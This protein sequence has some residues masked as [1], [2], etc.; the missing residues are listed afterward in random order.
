MNLRLSRLC[1]GSHDE[2]QSR[3]KKCKVWV[4]ETLPF[5]GGGQRV[6]LEVAR[7]LR[8]TGQYHC[9]FLLPDGGPLLEAVKADGFPYDTF[10][11]G[12]Y[13]LGVKNA[14]DYIRFT[15]D[16]L[17]A[18][19]LFARLIRRRRPCLVY[20]GGTRA[21]IWSAIFGQLFSI[22]ILWHIHHVMTDRTTV[23][24]LQWVGQLPAVRGI[25]CVS[26]CVRTQYPRLAE[27][28]LVLYNGVD[29]GRF[30]KV[31]P[32]HLR[33]Q[34]SLPDHANLL[35]LVGTLQPSKRQDILVRSLPYILS[36]FP[37]TYALIVGP[38][39]EEVAD[40]EHHL[41][42]LSSGLGVADHVVL[43]GYRNDVPSILLE[44]TAVVFTAEEACPLVALEAWAAQV[45]IVGPNVAGVAELIEAS[46]GGLQYKFG[47]ERALASKVLWLLRN[48][49]R[50][51]ELGRKG[52]EFVMEHSL[53]EFNLA[54]DRIVR[55]SVPHGTRQ[56]NSRSELP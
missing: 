7:S 46:G 50:A 33:S 19:V 12:K 5:L 14:C 26:Q 28:T 42:V 34:L 24:L 51:C 52:R 53:E 16:S 47:D 9:R 15:G 43:L 1:G 6:S 21:L 30:K 2:G 55:A 37:A 38:R 35:V 10:P 49:R 48:P 4:W 23:R 54:M 22:P 27:K 18:L 8:E 25:V 3:S 44:A 41:R 31:S 32:L 29:I 39:R 45:P 40:F 36:E 13:S 56:M 11:V 20:V 17:R